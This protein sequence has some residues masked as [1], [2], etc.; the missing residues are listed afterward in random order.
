MQPPRDRRAQAASAAC[1]QYRFAGERFTHKCF[2][3]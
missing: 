1:H 3:F 2:R